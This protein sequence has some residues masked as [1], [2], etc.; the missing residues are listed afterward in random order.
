M[1][2]YKYFTVPIIAEVLHFVMEFLKNVCTSKYVNLQYF[3]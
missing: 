1:L 3:I 2:S